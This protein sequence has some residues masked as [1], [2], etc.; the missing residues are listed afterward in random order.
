MTVVVVAGYFTV[1]GQLVIVSVWLLVAV[2]VWF[3]W[4]TVVGA[5]QK[6]V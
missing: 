1:H 5:G 3:P 4:T 2:Y 6:V